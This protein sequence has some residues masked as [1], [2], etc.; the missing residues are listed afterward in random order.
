MVTLPARARGCGQEGGWGGWDLWELWDVRWRG[1]AGNVRASNGDV[2]GGRVQ[3]GCGGGRLAG[4][5]QE[6]GLDRGM[7]AG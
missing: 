4:I 6:S 2:E 7:P 5:F 3:L 1:G